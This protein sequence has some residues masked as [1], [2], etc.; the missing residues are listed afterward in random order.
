MTRMS[1]LKTPPLACLFATCLIGCGST[2]SYQVEVANHTS[3]PVTLWLTKDG[4]PREEGW[5]SPEDLTTV[6]SE[7]QLQYDFVVVDPTRTG[8]T[9]KVSGQFPSGTHAVLRVY[10]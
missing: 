2:K 9:D 7:R 3:Q 4:P 6:Q 8:Y 1:F 5:L 10:A